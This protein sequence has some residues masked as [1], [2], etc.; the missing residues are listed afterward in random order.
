MDLRT[1]RDDGTPWDFST[2]EHRHDARRLQ[3]KDKPTWIIGSPPCPPFSIWNVGINFK[4][5]DPSRV[6]A[7]I[8]GGQSHLRFCAELYKKQVNAGRHFLDVHRASTVS[9]REPY[10]EA[11]TK[12][13]R[14]FTAVCDQCQFGLTTKSADGS[15]PELAMKPTGFLTSPQ[16][17]AEA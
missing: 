14:L 9:W 13:H 6:A 4:K 1:M 16:P 7:M 17:M 5:M 8:E 15:S 12:D 10:I 2:K 3:P 11:L